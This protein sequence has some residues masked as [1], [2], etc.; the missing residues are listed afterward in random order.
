MRKI[1]RQN[2]LSIALIGLFLVFQ[3]GLSIV[4]QHQYNHEQAEHRQLT[5]SYI[6]Y[7]ASAGFREATMEN[8]ESEFLQMFALAKRVFL[9]W[10][11]GSAQH[12]PEAERFA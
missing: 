7:I 10:S 6:E 3:L 1:W 12:C 11:N 5:I 8:W 9:D 2:G 4:G